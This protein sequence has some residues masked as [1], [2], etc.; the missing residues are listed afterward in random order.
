MSFTYKFG[1][2]TACGGAIPNKLCNKILLPKTSLQSFLRLSISL[3]SILIKITPSSRS[4]LAAKRNRGY[5]I[6]SQLVWYL[7]IVSGLDLVVCLVT[8]LYLESGS[9]KSSS[10]TKSLPVL[11]GGSMYIIFTLR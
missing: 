5:I 4:K 10:Y 3:S 7:P 11:Y 6:L 9:L 2:N 1:S 8:S